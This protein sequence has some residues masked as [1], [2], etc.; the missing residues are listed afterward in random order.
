M[1]QQLNIRSDTT[2]V[3]EQKV[4][5]TIEIIGIGKELMNKTE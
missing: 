3:T 1:G 4:K 5:N 2:N